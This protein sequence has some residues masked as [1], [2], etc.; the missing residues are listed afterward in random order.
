MNICSA[1][2]QENPLEAR[3]CGYCG[4][5]M[6]PISSQD[7]QALTD[8]LQPIE[9]ESPTML[10]EVKKVKGKGAE[11]LARVGRDGGMAGLVPEP[12]PKDKQTQGPRVVGKW[13]E[14]PVRVFPQKT[15]P[16]TKDTSK[17][18]DPGDGG[19]IVSAPM[20][21]PRPSTVPPGRA[22]S[23]GRPLTGKL[24]MVD[25]GPPMPV[26][27]PPVRVPMPSP[28]AP[29]QP[30]VRTT[31][32]P[33]R[34]TPPPAPPDASSPKPP[35]PGQADGRTARRYRRFP[36]KV[37]VG[38]ATEHN[39]YTGFMENLSSGGLFIATHQPAQIGEVMEITFTVPGIPGA[40]VAI[41][42]VTWTREYD[43]TN[44]DMVPGMGLKF[45][46]LDQKVRAAVELFIKHREP[47]FF[48]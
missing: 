14:P 17:G 38:Y 31:P 24:K 9:V 8:Q 39:F 37:E 3:F 12:A 48:D 5:R 22:T 18:R 35:L 15:G 13:E 19:L 36:L 30:P 42:Q 46:Q 23:E 44:E 32:P 29:I 11:H 26:S 7:W 47:I 33:A 6:V 45:I 34:V 4:F 25:S 20:P 40:C 10:T 16:G 21:S 43:A 41:A 1:C 2:R 28:H 27:E